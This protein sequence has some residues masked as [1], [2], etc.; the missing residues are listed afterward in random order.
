MTQDDWD[1]NINFD[2][3]KLL[4]QLV[5]KIKSKHYKISEL[6]AIMKLEGVKTVGVYNLKES[7]RNIVP[8]LSEDDALFL[9]RY[10]CKGKG[11][12]GIEQVVDVLKVS[13]LEN[14]KVA[15]DGEWEDKF[16]GRIKR[17]MID[18]QIY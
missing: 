17:K 7:L 16:I 4:K 10:I 13:S 14:E 15:V 1:K 5:D 12:I 3:N 8:S 2:S 9:S 6:L 11:E 18:S